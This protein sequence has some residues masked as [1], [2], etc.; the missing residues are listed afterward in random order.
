MAASLRGAMADVV[1]LQIASCVIEETSIGPGKLIARFRCACRDGQKIATGAG[2]DAGS[3]GRHSR[4]FFEDN[5]PICS[6]APK[7]TNTRE[8]AACRTRPRSGCHGDIKSRAFQ[9]YKRITFLIVKIRRY[10]LVMQCEGGFD[11]TRNSRS[12][13]QMAE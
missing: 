13:F 9:N 4:S 2:L 12:G 5:M 8:A 7:R 1:K 6:A 3:S 10:L 11:K